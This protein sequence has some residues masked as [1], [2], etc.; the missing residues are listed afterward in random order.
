MMSAGRWL[1][2]AVTDLVVVM[3]VLSIQLF[4]VCTYRALRRCGCAD[5]SGRGLFIQ[6]PASAQAQGNT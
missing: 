2:S 4:S 1:Q 5:H 3:Q 6:V